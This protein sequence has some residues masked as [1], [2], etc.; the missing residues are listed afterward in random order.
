DSTKDT[1]ITWWGTT[2][3][4]SKESELLLGLDLQGGISVT[5][6]V[7]LDGLIKNL[8]NNPRDPQ[9][10]KALTLANQKKVSSSSNLVDLFAQ[11]Y[12]EI[13][14]TGKLAPLFA[15]ANRN[16]L[17][18]DASDESVTSYLH[19]MANA[20]MTQTF[21]V[22]QTRIDKFGVAQP[23]ISLDQ[24]RGVIA[25]ELAGATDP[26]RVRKY[27]QSTANL[28][29]WEV[30]NISELATSFGNADKALEN[31][32][33]GIKEAS[34]AMRRQDSLKTAGDSTQKDTTT[35]PNAHPLL[36]QRVIHFAQ[37][38][39]DPK[40]GQARYEPYL[41]AVALKDTS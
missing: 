28:Q 13:N 35:G 23:S 31:E 18:F 26:E 9:L 5:L 16:K 12:K 15:N 36:N 11:S 2:Y 10:L 21:K 7:A 32:L 1:K 4:K 30:Y 41:A 25:V 29:F 8:S 37:A 38:R 6:D 24:N 20:A 3:Q 27:L 34:A 14:P 39:Q 19:D 17:K 22:L 40:T 33:N